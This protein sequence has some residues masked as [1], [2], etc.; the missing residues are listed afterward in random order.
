MRASLSYYRYYYAHVSSGWPFG[1]G[2]PEVAAAN[3]M[4][5]G[6]LFDTAGEDSTYK[7]GE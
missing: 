3:E 2:S 6:R 5:Y 1:S 4:L 7:P